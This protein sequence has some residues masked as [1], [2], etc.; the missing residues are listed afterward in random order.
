MDRY[1]AE[2]LACLHR[3]FHGSSVRPRISQ[4]L[5]GHWRLSDR[6]RYDNA[7]PMYKLLPDN[8]YAGYLCWTWHWHYLPSGSGYHRSI[9][10]DQPAGCNGGGGLRHKYW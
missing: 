3:S 10:Y 4:D 5:T 7:K 8:A 1:T 2:L 6:I 9:I